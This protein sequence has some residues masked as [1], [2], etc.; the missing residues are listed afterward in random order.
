[1]ADILITHGSLITMDP[2]REVIEDGAI[3]IERNRIIDIGRTADLIAKHRAPKVIDAKRMVAMPG[4]IDGHAHAGHGLVRALA[5]EDWGTWGK[6]CEKIYSSGTTEEFWYTEA[7]LS[8]LERLKC[9]VTTGVTM[10]GGG[11]NLFRTDDPIFGDRHCEAVSQVGTR[12]FVVV[13]P[14]PPPLPRTYA[15]WHGSSRRDVIVRFEDILA[16]CETLI[17][18]WHKKNDG[19][20]HICLTIPPYKAEIALTQQ[21]FDDFKVRS[22]AIRKLQR[23]HGVLFHQD[24]HRRG[25]IKFA[26]E[27][28]KDPLGPDSSLGHS[29][30]LTAEEIEICRKT[31]V[32]IV[33]NPT[34]NV[35]ARGRCPVPELLEAGVTVILGSDG[36][37][38]N[39][40]Y[41]MFRHMVYCLHYHRTYYRNTTYLPGGK[42]LEMV[43]IDSARA[44][45]MEKEIGSLE[46]G[47]R[48]DI[49][50]VDTAKPH[51]SPFNMPVYQVLYFANGSDVDTVIVDGKV[52]MENRVV[53]TVNEEEVMGMAQRESEAVLDRMGLRDLLK[54]HEQFWGH[55]Q[56]PWVHPQPSL[57]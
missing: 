19:Q 18:R 2:K 8:A 22:Q 26:Y 45:G 10:L 15:R 14:C 57:F 35:S 3:A 41:D 12:S 42:V 36:N 16:T 4:L 11:P 38:P 29:V 40:G 30:N 13:G 37:S 23:K 9:G 27:T 44:L 21:Q 6:A 33:H 7:L 50:L 46:V 49:I 48:A 31:D 20:I 25:S 51:L 32:R 17:K 43:T 47:K 55:A 53:K 56:Y 34:S 1:M 52:L 24:G 28:L 39:T 54:T 5:G